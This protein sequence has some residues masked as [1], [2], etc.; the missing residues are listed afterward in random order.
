MADCSIV[1]G[2]CLVGLLPAERSQ[3]SS[4]L[5]M[6][7]SATIPASPRMGQ[8]MCRQAESLHQGAD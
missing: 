5:G 3:A 6:C 2:D 4:I 1:L 7:D 8:W